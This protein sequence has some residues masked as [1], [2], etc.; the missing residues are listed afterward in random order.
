[1]DGHQRFNL[2]MCEE[3]VLIRFC[4]RHEAAAFLLPLVYNKELV[5][6]A[7]R[8]YTHALGCGLNAVSQSCCQRAEGDSYIVDL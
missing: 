1:M 4:L 5:T 7:I 3:S 6:S 8:E 2:Y